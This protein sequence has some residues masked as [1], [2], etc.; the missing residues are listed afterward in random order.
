MLRS[1]S[2]Q[3][4][5]ARVTAIIAPVTA[6]TVAVIVQNQ[7]VVAITVRAIAPIAA[8]I[9][10]ISAPANATITKNENTPS[11]V[12]NKPACLSGLFLNVSN[13]STYP[14]R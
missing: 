5:I 13:R 8:V 10:H 7:R 12:R 9:V 4:K 2:K 3:G 11:Q 6:T 1:I 14:L